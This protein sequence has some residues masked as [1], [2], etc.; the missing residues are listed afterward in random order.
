MTV[1]NPQERSAPLRQRALFWLFAATASWGLSFP[2]LKALYAG[3]QRAVPDASSWFLAAWVLAARFGFA[4]M[5][6]L[7]FVLARRGITRREA[8][9]GAVL[10]V[11]AACGLLLQADGLAYTSASTSAFLTQFYCVILPIVGCVRNRRPPPLRV[12]LCT[13]MVLAG[14]YILSGFDWMRFRLGRGEFETILATLFFTAQILV[15]EARRYSLN[16]P[17]FTTL[18]MFCIIAAACA[19]FATATAPSLRAMTDV[20]SAPAHGEILAILTLLCTLFSFI[21]MN[22]WQKHVTATEAGIA[23]SVEP[24]FALGFALFFPHLLNRFTGSGYENEVITSR[25]LAG[26]GL[27]LSATVLL[28]IPPRSRRG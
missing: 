18:G 20:W 8:E 7:P 27:M 3:Q 2:L 14:G 11:A 16:R 28:Q 15:L 22:V 23:Y 26:G 21:L 5:L 19:A 1:Q 17:L 4:A 24:V 13:L 6:M 25:L 10:G 12:V 9:H